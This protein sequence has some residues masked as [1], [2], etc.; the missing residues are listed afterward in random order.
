MA[1]RI[2][3]FRV[4]AKYLVNRFVMLA[5][6][7]DYFQ[8]QLQTLSTGSTAKGLKA[9]KLPMLRIITPPV[10]EQDAI[11]EFVDAETTRTDALVRKV[12]EA[13]DRLKELRTALISAAVTGKIDVRDATIPLRDAE[14]KLI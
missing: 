2:I 11:C 6:M 10:N 4:D 13:I 3:R 12:G 1:Q 8:A 7:S 14:S 9:S 5:M